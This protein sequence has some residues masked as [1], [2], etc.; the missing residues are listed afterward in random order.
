MKFSGLFA[1][2]LIVT[3]AGCDR[4]N[5][6][7]ACFGVVNVPVVSASGLESYITDDNLLS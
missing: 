5:L 3:S 1:P 4:K 7:A 2:F 6:S